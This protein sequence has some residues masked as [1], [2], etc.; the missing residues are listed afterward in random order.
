M[1]IPTAMLSPRK[2]HATKID[3]SRTYATATPPVADIFS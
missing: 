3:Y 1:P 2:T